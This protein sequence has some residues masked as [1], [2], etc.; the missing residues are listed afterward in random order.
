MIMDHEA[1]DC[2]L[3]SENMLIREIPPVFNNYPNVVNIGVSLVPQWMKHWCIVLVGENLNL[4][5]YTF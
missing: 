4:C 3:D 1:S 2:L 5:R